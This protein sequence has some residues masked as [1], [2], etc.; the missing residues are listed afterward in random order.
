MTRIVVGIDAQTGL[1]RIERDECL[2]LL[3]GDVVGRLAVMDGS[4][5]AIFPVNYAM[6]GEDVVFR[7]DPGTK[8]GAE[9]RGLACFEVDGIDR[10]A[11]VG[12]SVVATGR[13]EEVTR[14]SASTLRRL[15]ELPVAP[16]AAGEKA[17]WM[18]L[19]ASRITGRRVGPT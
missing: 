12:W 13:L 5:P 1:E 9:Q 6:D 4:A 19:V 3:A 8:L 7:T 17:H 2:R 15:Q 18:R 16:W 10:N 14:Y 11:H